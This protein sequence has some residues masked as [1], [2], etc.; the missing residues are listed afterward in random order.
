MGNYNTRKMRDYQATRRNQQ[1]SHKSDAEDA[2]VL[3]AFVA[4]ELSEG[5][6]S[7]TLGI[8]RV[9]LRDKVLR[10]VAAGCER[11]AVSPPDARFE[12]WS[13]VMSVA[14]EIE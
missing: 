13:V 8:D 11:A 1:R 12:T 2:D 6:A 7:R 3:L 5:R 4:G 14:G 9:S 10:M